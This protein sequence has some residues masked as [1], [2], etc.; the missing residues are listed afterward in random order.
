MEADCLLH[1]RK[2]EYLKYES[3]LFHGNVELASN[4]FFEGGYGVVRFHLE[5]NL[6]TRDELNRHDHGL[7]SGGDRGFLSRN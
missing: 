5:V 3:L 7:V 1:L 6:L 2:Y 4:E